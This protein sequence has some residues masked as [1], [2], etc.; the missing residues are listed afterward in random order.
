MVKEIDTQSGLQPD[1]ALMIEDLHAEA[2]QQYALAVP[3]SSASG[4]SSS[5]LPADAVVP[6]YGTAESTKDVVQALTFYPSTIDKFRGSQTPPVVTGD[7]AS[8]AS[9]SVRTWTT[10]SMG[11]AARQAQHLDSMDAMSRNFQERMAASLSLHPVPAERLEEM[12][13]TTEGPAAVEGD[14]SMLL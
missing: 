6:V 14:T 1:M 10:L 13:F 4:A 7:T 5:R 2:S 3:S 9:S 12:N 8:S 11:V